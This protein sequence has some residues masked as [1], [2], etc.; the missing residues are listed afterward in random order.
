[1]RSVLDPIAG[2][3][4]GAACPSENPLIRASE[5]PQPTIR[6][7]PARR[8]RRRSS[9][10]RE[11]PRARERADSEKRYLK[12]EL[13][14][15][16]VGVP[17]I[18]KVASSAAKSTE[19]EHDELVA[20]AEALWARGIHECRMAAVELLDLRA[21]LLG[22]PD[23][24]LLERLVRE[25]RTWALVDGLA[26]SV[27]GPLIDRH[28]ELEAELERWAADPD[29]W[30][31]RSALLAHPLALRRGE[32]DFERFARYADA[33]LEEQEFFIRKAIGWVLRDTSRGRPALVFEWLEPR[34][35]RASGVTLREAVKYLSDGQRQAIQA[36]RTRAG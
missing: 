16:G 14:H 9:G 20:A 25:S 7:W 19:L 24:A 6:R 4:V 36:S 12:S 3:H 23:L 32:G 8:S 35:H 2:W 1:L 11:R 26:A 30:V 18:R 22:P 13:D 27:A 15:L 10:S 28:P 34:A 5:M 17:A 29:F 31:R 33:M 21:D